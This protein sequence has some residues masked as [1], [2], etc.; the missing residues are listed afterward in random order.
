LLDRENH[1]ELPFRALDYHQDRVI[2][3]GPAAAAA[4]S[5]ATPAQP[6]AGGDTTIGRSFPSR[7]RGLAVPRNFCSDQVTDDVDRQVDVPLPGLPVDDRGPQGHSSWSLPTDDD[8]VAM[9]VVWSAL[10]RPTYFGGAPH[11]GIDSVLVRL[12]A[13][14]LAPVRTGERHVIASWPI[15]SG[16]R[17]RL[18]GVALW[19]AGG[20]P[21]AIGRGLWIELRASKSA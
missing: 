21:C 18:A 16:G 6:G 2:A 12:T 11:G 20:E 3:V 9:E 14:V 19:S 17:N 10:D 8:A 15:S 7:P 5:A 13:C 1:A 4:V